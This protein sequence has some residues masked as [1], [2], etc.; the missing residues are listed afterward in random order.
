VNF[1]G[2]RSSRVQPPS[3]ILNQAP[4]QKQPRS[5]AEAGLLRATAIALGRSLGTLWAFFKEDLGPVF[6]WGRL[7]ERNVNFVCNAR[8]ARS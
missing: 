6:G 3:Q 1:K 7:S 8:S 2:P 5:A 4:A